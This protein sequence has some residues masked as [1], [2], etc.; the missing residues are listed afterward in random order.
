MSASS[1]G[2]AGGAVG[3]GTGGTASTTAPG[4]YFKRYQL[5]IYVHFCM[6]KGRYKI[7]VL[8]ALVCI[9]NIFLISDC[10]CRCVCVRQ[11]QCAFLLVFFCAYIRAQCLL[12]FSFTSHIR[13]IWLRL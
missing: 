9:H 11:C 13:S 4:M 8:L 6:F 10:T 7:Y 3:G 2:G 5:S 1:E 12:Q